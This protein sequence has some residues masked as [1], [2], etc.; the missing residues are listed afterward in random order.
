MMKE[1]YI[2]Q[3]IREFHNMDI[4]LVEYPSACRELR[5]KINKVADMATNIIKTKYINKEITKETYN[6]NI[7]HIEYLRM[8][9]QRQV[10]SI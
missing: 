10:N 4:P 5:A 3:Q 7:N 8:K 1:T 9:Y 6:R 2:M